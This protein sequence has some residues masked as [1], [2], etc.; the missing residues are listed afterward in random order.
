MRLC[1]VTEYFDDTGSTPTILSNLTRYL[2]AQHPELDVDVITSRNLYRGSE[3]RESEKTADG[4]NV[5]RLNTPKSNRPATLMRGGPGMGGELAAGGG[6]L[7][8][9]RPD[10]RRVVTNTP[11]APPDA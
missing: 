10:P 9:G 11:P 7:V 6:V 5:I 2:K 8:Q 1:I 3:R 4:S